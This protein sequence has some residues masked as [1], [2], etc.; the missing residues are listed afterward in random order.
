MERRYGSFSRSLRVPDTVDEAKVEARF[1]N[2]VL[3]VTLPK[4]PE[5]ASKQRRI[6]IKKK[7][8]VARASS[9]SYVALM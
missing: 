6:E 7:L 5:A 4:R 1:E 3:K 9:R 8:A 2:G